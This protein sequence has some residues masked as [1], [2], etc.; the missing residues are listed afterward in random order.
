LIT[1]FICIL[2]EALMGFYQSDRQQLTVPMTDA[3]PKLLAERMGAI[4]ATSNRRMLE[5]K[6]PGHPFFARIMI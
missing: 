2:K 3:V 5:I 4:L 6:D 1:K